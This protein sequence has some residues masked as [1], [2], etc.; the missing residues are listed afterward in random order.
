MMNDE[1]FINIV[2]NVFEE[3]NVDNIIEKIGGESDKDGPLFNDGDCISDCS[4]DFTQFDEKIL[5]S[6]QM[7]MMIIFMNFYKLLFF[8][9]C[10]GAI[11]AI[12]DAPYN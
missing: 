2:D 5:D 4:E 7:F 1:D 3:M 11:R 12:N 9:M 6:S 8:V 10:Q